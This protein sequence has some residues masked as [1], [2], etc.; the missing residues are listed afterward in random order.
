MTRQM[1]TVQKGTYGLGPNLASTGPTLRFSHGGRDE[2][3]DAMLIAYAETGDGLAIMVNANDNSRAVARIVNYVARTYNWPSYPQPP[4]E[5]VELANDPALAQAV[6]GRYE[7]AN[8]NMVA[9]VAKDGRVFF[10]VNGL[11]DEAFVIAKDGRLV[12]TERPV[13]FRPVRGANGEI[14]ALELIQ[15]SATRRIP[16]IGPLFSDHAAADPDPELTRKLKGV[17]DAF[18]AGGEAVTS[19]QLLTAGA[20]TNLARAIPDLKGARSITFAG[21]QDVTG[22][23]IERHGHKI[24]RVL[25]YRVETPAG[26]KLVLVHLDPD[27]LVA[28]YDVVSR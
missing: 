21:A 16:R 26:V 27:G 13:S 8:N 22:R 10:D 25:H 14:E 19:S 28:D 7:F 9:L 5:T 20:R 12:S 3:F 17:L 6:A 24:A 23:G 18:A 1:L 4:V 15:G 2:G 11:P